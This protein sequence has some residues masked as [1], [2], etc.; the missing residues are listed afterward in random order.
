MRD[1]VIG[2]F[3]DSSVTGKPVGDDLREGKPTSLLARAVA[4]AEPAELDVLARV[5]APHLGDDEVAKIQQVIVDTGA[6]DEL[7]ARIAT[8]AAEAV[9]ALDRVAIDATAREELRA[10]AAFV[11]ARVD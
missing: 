5:G 7:E 3:G 11:V 1:D 8:L 6:L 2:A 4:R 9:A 10:L